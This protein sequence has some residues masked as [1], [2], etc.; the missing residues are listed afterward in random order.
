MERANSK[1]ELEAA[2]DGSHRDS[3]ATGKE[4]PTG[5]DRT[6]KIASWLC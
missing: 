5:W 4:I 3:L 2:W 6:S 1:D